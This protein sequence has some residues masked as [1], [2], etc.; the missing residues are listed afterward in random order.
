MLPIAETPAQ[1]RAVLPVVAHRIWEIFVAVGVVLGYLSYFQP[2]LSVTPQQA[3]DPSKP[4]SVPFII[5]NNGYLPFRDVEFLCGIR[6]VKG[7]ENRTLGKFALRFPHNRLSVLEPGKPATISCDFFAAKGF[8]FFPVISADIAIIVQFRPQ[9]LPWSK[10][11]SFRFIT[12]EAADNKLLWFP[13]P[14]EKNEK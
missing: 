13:Q 9:L 12:T 6:E 1:N 2:R 11:E 14:E 3:L 7:T 4:F 5:A 10:R 8:E